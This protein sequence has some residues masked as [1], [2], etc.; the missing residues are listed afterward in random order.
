MIWCVE[1]D[2][3]IRDIEIYT[4]KSTGFEARGFED[5]DSFWKELV[6]TDTL[7][8]LVL[9]DIML[10]GEDGITLLKKMRQ[11][12]KT[13]DIPVIMATAKGMEF[14]KVQSLDTGADDYL[15]K[16][17]SLE[18]LAARVRAALRISHGFKDKGSA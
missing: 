7:P 5:G 18:E 4:L 3:S 12:P 6:S 2:N 13:E 1:D 8:E 15:V 9:M 11:L 17:F 16:P 10:P 14:D